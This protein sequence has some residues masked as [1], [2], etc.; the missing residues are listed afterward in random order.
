MEEIG[1]CVPRNERFYPNYYCHDFEAY[2]S[3]Q[4]FPESG[5]K[6][7]FEARHIPLSVGIAANVPDFTKGVYIFVTNGREAELI[8]K[9]LDYLEKASAA[10]CQ[11]IKKIRI[12]FRVIGDKSKCEKRKFSKRI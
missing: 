4:N 2:F 11:L 3:Q 10:A 1:I 8:Q 12:C 6:L 7:T 9:M 5:P